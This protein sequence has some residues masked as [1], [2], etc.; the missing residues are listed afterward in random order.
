MD[1]D[2]KNVDRLLHMSKKIFKKRTGNELI[3]S[4]Y[5]REVIKGLLD[6]N[7]IVEND[8]IFKKSDIFMFF[9]K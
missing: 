4:D 6:K 1:K 3:I 8:F 7:D 5:E 2:Y 9:K